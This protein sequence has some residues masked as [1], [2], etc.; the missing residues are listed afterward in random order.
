MGEILFIHS[1]PE[2]GVRWEPS[3]EGNLKARALT[4]FGTPGNRYSILVMEK[5]ILTEKL[6][7]PEGCWLLCDRWMDGTPVR[8]DL[9]WAVDAGGSGCVVLCGRENPCAVDNSA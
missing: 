9:Q 1:R 4:V 5:K 3:P 8:F 2:D 6:A 7:G